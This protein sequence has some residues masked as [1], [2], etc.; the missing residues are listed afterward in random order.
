MLALVLAP[1]LVLALVDYHAVA[2]VLVGLARIA[3]VPVLVALAYSPVL[4]RI[5]L[6][7]L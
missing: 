2:P 6:I 5:L 4:V 1:V 3:L 7:A